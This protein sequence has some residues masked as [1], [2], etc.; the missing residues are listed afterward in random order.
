[1]GQMIHTIEIQRRFLSDEKWEVT[2]ENMLVERQN[3]ELRLIP[4]FL[5][6]KETNMFL[7]RTHIVINGHNRG[8]GKIKPE[9]IFFN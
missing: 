3:K 5:A 9:V 2:W 6:Y 4:V 1:M 8:T 7:K